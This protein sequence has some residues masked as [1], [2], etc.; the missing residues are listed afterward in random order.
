[1][2]ANEK[3]LLEA[4]NVS[5]HFPVKNFFGRVTQVVK[6]VDHVTFSIKKGETF[7]LVGESGCGKSTLGRTLIRMYQPTS[8]TITFDGTDISSLKGKELLKYHKRMQIIF[9]DPYSALDP[10]Q[11][12]REIMAEPISVFEKLSASQMDEKIA[13][14]LKMVG[15]KPDDME[16]YAYEFSGGQRQRIGIARALS[17]NPEFLLCDEPISA[18]DVSIQAQVVNV[19]E[20]LQ[21]EMGLTYLF[22]AHDLSMVRHISN[23]IGVMYL[24]K[25]VEIGESDEVYDNPLHPYTQALLASIPIAD[26]K[27]AL[28]LEKAGIEGDLPSPLNIPSGCRFHTRCPYA[29]EECRTKEPEFEERTPGHFVACWKK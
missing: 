4:V 23:R 20:D 3:Y 29:T 6:A 15:M 21:K 17:V 19:L 11:N 16:K 2:D 14:L 27:R 7:G 26:P 9:Q 22:V 13:S 25:I 28:S 1:M 24:G 8:G 12:V 10:H 18:L 5:K